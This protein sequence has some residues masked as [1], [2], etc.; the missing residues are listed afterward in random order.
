LQLECPDVGRFAGFI[1]ALDPTLVRG[2]GFGVV[3][4]ADGRTAG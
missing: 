2:G 3:G 1:K 4:L